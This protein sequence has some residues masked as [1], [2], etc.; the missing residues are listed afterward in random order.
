MTSG[1]V[2][3]SGYDFG[4][5]TLHNAVDSSAC[6]F[7]IIQ[8]LQSVQT[9]PNDCS[10]QDE[11]DGQRLRTIV[12]FQ[13]MQSVQS[14]STFPPLDKFPLPSLTRA[15]SPNNV[16]FARLS[17]VL[18][19]D[20]QH[21]FSLLECSFIHLLQRGSP[22]SS[23]LSLLIASSSPSSPRLETASS[24]SSPPLPLILCS[25]ACHLLNLPLQLSERLL[26]N[27]SFH[28]LCISIHLT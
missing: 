19:L 15:N 14:Q 1:T 27:A 10:D 7:R 13:S 6:Q 11:H 25:F 18:Q 21:L 2:W 20:L 23:S 16:L 3:I 24:H 9:H 5:L 8:S 28:L 4:Q 22:F 26:L 17:V 12:D